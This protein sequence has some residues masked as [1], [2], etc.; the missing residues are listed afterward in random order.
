MLV[1]PFDVAP[2]KTYGTNRGSNV[3][4]ARKRFDVSIT[5]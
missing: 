1:T 5:I 3:A 4:V 2:V